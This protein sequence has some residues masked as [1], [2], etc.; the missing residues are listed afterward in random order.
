MLR[1]AL[2]GEASTDAALIHLYC[3]PQRSVAGQLSLPECVLC[4]ERALEVYCLL[5]FD[6]R[7]GVQSLAVAEAH[8]QV[9][10]VFSGRPS[11]MCRPPRTELFG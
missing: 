6:T 10:C 11:G 5:A 2:T 7:C 1:Q 3:A 8:D 9:T 4:A